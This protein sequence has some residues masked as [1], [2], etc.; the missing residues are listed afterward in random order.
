[1]AGS[2]D[3][4]LDGAVA[5]LTLDNAAK[6]NSI[7]LAM[8]AAL[9]GAARAI[10]A[11][12]TLGAVILRGA[13]TR[14]FCAGGDFDAMTAGDI[15]A[16]MRGMDAAL[17]EAMAAMARIA[18]PIVAA[19]NGACFGAG[20]QIMLAADIRIASDDARFGIPAASLGI[21]YPLPAIAEMIRS[22]GPG[23][24][25]H[26][27]LGGAPIDAAAALER[28]LVAQVVP[29]AE[30]EAEA[31]SLAQRIAAGPRAAA[32]AYKA[33]IRGLAEGRAESDLRE[34]QKRAHESPE[35]I[36]RLAAVAAKRA[37]G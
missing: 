30:L 29:K 14:A 19:V 25:A 24:A 17:E 3:L 35:M 26:F 2:V 33:I 7:D 27:L 8:C 31:A 1:M 23:A 28:G 18:V 13:G 21:V 32:R 11:D 9:T 37:K 4:Q 36:E 34:L 16:A 20:V 12:E 10:A 22:A 6:R 5:T 15:A